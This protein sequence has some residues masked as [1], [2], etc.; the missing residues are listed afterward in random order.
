MAY[1]DIFYYVLNFLNFTNEL[2]ITFE[3]CVVFF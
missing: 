1:V 3:T 2:C